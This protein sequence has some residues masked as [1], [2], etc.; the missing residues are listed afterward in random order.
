LE[1]IGTYLLTEDGTKYVIIRG[2][3]KILPSELKSPHLAEAIALQLAYKMA[4][5][6]RPDRPDLEQ[7]LW[8][9]YQAKI[10]ESRNRTALDQKDQE[11]PTLFRQRAKLWVE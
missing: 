3:K 2:V 11:R 10:A 5:I 6:L 9:Q 7:K 8:Q 4:P 1:S